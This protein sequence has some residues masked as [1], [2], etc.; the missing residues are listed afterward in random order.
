MSCA[1]LPQH[2]GIMCRDVATVKHLT[3][4]LISTLCNL[5][6]LIDAPC[7]VCFCIFQSCVYV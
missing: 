3:V 4:L 5:Q 6:K 2:G 7:H 1:L